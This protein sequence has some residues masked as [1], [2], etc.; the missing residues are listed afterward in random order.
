MAKVRIH[1][2]T[3]PGDEPCAQT[4]ITHDWLRL[5][6]LECLVYRAALIARFGPPPPRA[7]ISCAHNTHD[8]GNTIDLVVFYDDDDDG[9]GGGAAWAES[10]ADGLARWQ[11]GGFIAPIVYDAAGQPSLCSLSD[12]RESIVTTI[13]RLTRLVR[14]G[15]GTDADRSMI[16]NLRS[17]YSSH[18]VTADERLAVIYS[19]SETPA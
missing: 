14:D 12:V 15:Y 7:E 10:V 9:P 4:G 17:A 3:A 2:G 16:A 5:Q 8:F 19:G 11:D 1:I 13:V 6:Q 18:S